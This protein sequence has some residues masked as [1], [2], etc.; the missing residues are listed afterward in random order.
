[1]YKSWENGWKSKNL[2]N[3]GPEFRAWNFDMN[4]KHIW[5]V[6]DHWKQ[7]EYAILDK[8]NE[9]NLSYLLKTYFRAQF[10]TE[11][12]QILGSELW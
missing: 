2:L 7:S 9:P 10:G 11:G 3:S 5:L 8:W 6:K 12:P 1:M 4:K